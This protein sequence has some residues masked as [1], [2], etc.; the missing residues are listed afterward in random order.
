MPSFLGYLR[1]AFR[2]LGSRQE[3]GILIEVV[4]SAGLVAAIG[5]A[6][7]SGVD[8][9]VKTA[10][11]NRE[12]SVAAALAEQDQERMRSFTTVQLEGYSQTRTVT[13]RGI[14]Y[15]VQST[16]GWVWDGSATVSCTN[17]SSRTNYMR[18]A[19]TVTPAGNRPGRPVTVSSLMAPT[20]DS[21]TMGVMIINRSGGPRPGLTVNVTGNGQS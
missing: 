15:T 19:S 10:V 3:G 5:T 18:I 12:R 7:L 6:V 4:V 14:P 17:N 11:Q 8:G 16:T 13:V 20:N 9:S 2:R 21:G 1:A